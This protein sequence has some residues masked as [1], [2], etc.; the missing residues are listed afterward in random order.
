MLIGALID[1]MAALASSI[2][3]WSLPN[4]KSNTFL[5]TEKNPS[6]VPR[7]TPASINFSLNY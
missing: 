3:F 2:T 5:G 1:P 6:P 4:P 7:Y